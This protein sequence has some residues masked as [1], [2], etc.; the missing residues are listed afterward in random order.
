M[1]GL[2]FDRRFKLSGERVR[3]VHGSPRK[4]NEYL[5]ADKPAPHV[6]ADRGGR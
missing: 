3:L 5:F 2:P 1:R 4:V 6:R